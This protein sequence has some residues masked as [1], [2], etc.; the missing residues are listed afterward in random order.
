[1]RRPALG[2]SLSSA[3]LV[4]L[5]TV[6]CACGGGG[7]GGK[8]SNAP[9]FYVT[10][11]ANAGAGSLRQVIADAP[12][13]ATVAFAP[14]LS[15]GIVTLTASINFG[16][17]VTIDGSGPGGDVTLDGNN[18]TRLFLLEDVEDVVLRHLILRRGNTGG[19]GGILAAESGSLRLE[20]VQLLDGLANGYGGAIVASNCDV[21]MI[22]CH[23]QG[24]IADA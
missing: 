3:A 16:Q 23:V 7:G 14:A 4:A 20:N 21:Q 5:A 18:T 10:S 8:G 6:L 22:G 11:L 12:S 17:P 1:M 13:G 15:G 9:T 24:C 2:L 19:D